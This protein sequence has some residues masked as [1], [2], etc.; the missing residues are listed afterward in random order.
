MQLRFMFLATLQ[1]K[2]SI[3]VAKNKRGEKKFGEAKGKA[4]KVVLKAMKV[5]EAKKKKKKAGEF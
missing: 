2:L 1:S 5:K 3:K 4:K